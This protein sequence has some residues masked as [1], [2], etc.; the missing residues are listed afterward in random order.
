MSARQVTDERRA[1]PLLRAL[2]WV[3]VGLAPIAALMLLLGEGNGPLRIAAVLAVL[4]VVLIGL[5]ITLRDDAETVRLDVEET[6]V[7]LVDRLRAEFR[8]DIGTAA[9]STHRSLGEHLQR[10]HDNVE[11]LRG[12]IESARAEPAHGG[13]TGVDARG[14]S[15]GT[16][17]S[18]YDRGGYEPAAGTG[19]GSGTHSR[20]AGAYGGRAAHLG[21]VPHTMGQGMSGGHQQAVGSAVPYGRA[22]LPGGGATAQHVPGGV[23]RHTETVQVTTRQT[24]VDPHGEASGAGTTA[25]AGGVYGGRGGAGE[26]DWPE[27]ASRGRRSIDYDEDS[28]TDQRVREP[29]G[30]DV[31]RSG[32]YDRGDVDAAHDE[33]WSDLRA[34]DRWASVRS[35]ERGRELRMGE[36]RA[37]VRADETGTEMRVEDRW[38]SVRR[39]EPEPGIEDSWR[40]NG[41]G[42]AGYRSWGEQGWEQ[43]TSLPALPAGGADPASA[44]GRGWSEPEREPVRRGRRSR[45][46]DQ[47]FGYPPEDDVPRAG[48]ARRPDFERSD[49]RWR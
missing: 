49:E 46:D 18:G 15:H 41:S 13:Q 48:G 9:R 45:D 26:G 3:G 40:E 47:Q 1:R 37:A 43:R 21:P 16:D 33:R 10:L 28:W 14:F 8:N 4:A 36:R 32:P 17:P 6:L 7:D 23:V 30:G 12:Q 38:A 11:A 44:W 34:G 42:S 22:S 5:S 20:P 35:N 39:E 31:R 25:Y 24:I 27:Q 2:F 19:A 29:R